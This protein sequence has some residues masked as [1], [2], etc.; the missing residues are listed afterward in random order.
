MTS[1]PRTCYQDKAGAIWQF[2]VGL[3]LCGAA[4]Y[5]VY[6]I[7]YWSHRGVH[8]LLR[9]LFVLLNQSGGKWVCAGLI[10]LLGVAFCCAALRRLLTAPDRQRFAEGAMVLESAQWINRAERQEAVSASS[11]SE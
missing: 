5:L 7:N 4:A 2:T 8:V 6:V 9:D 3:A 11:P 1:H 10:A